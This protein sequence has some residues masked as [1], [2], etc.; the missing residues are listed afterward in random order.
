M[1]EITITI[2]EPGEW[3]RPMRLEWEGGLAELKQLAA[4][5]VQWTEDVRTDPARRHEVI[6]DPLVNRSTLAVFAAAALESPAPDRP[7]LVGDYLE[8]YEIEVVT[9]AHPEKGLETIV[10]ARPRADIAGSA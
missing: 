2:E 4:Q 1:P 9:R 8:L 3:R 7:G 6:S 5:G 10:H